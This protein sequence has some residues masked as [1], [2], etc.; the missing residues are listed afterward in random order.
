M[1]RFAFLSMI[2]ALVFVMLGTT[3]TASAAAYTV[4]KGRDASRARSGGVYF[5]RSNFQAVS[6]INAKKV[7]SVT[8]TQLL[9]LAVG[10]NITLSNG[11]AIQRIAE[12]DAKGRTVFVVFVNGVQS[13]VALTVGTYGK[14][15]N[16]VRLLVG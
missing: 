9:A 15:T 10:A 14:Y 1:K 4:P 8:S 3:S 12:K 6:I 16:V 11:V 5:A 13:K 7:D 2:V